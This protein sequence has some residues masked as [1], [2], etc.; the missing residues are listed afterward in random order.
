MTPDELNFDHER[1]ESCIA[2]INTL[3]ARVGLGPGAAPVDLEPIQ[4][5]LSAAWSKINLLVGQ[6]DALEVARANMATRHAE[7]NHDGQ[8]AT[9]G[10]THPKYEHHHDERY[11]PTEHP[12]DDLIGQLRETVVAAIA[13]ADQVQVVGNVV[14][15]LSEAI[16]EIRR[17]VT[18]MQGDSLRAITEWTASLESTDGRLDALR[19]RVGQ[20]FE[21]E[22]FK[23]LKAR[24]DGINNLVLTYHD[25]HA[26]RLHRHDTDYAPTEHEHQ[27]THPFLSQ[28]WATGSTTSVQEGA[29]V[30]GHVH[31]Y[32]V[33][34]EDGVWR[35][36]ICDEPKPAEEE[37]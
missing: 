11:A 27:H 29:I 17:H 18:M 8:Y 23:A 15:T 5:D 35:C 2:A 13:L 3:S 6:V 26:S 16:D 24:L 34:R 25:L 30:S 28:S 12:H 14:A 9:P 36:T 37:N 19:M 21:A 32:G 33:M 7:H 20:I 31:Q 1:L 4:A 22:P 10:H